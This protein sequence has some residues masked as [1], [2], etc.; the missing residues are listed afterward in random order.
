[1][2]IFLFAAM[3]LLLSA[4][5]TQPATSPASTRQPLPDFPPLSLFYKHPSED[6]NSECEKFRAQS[7]LHHCNDNQFDL[8]SLQKALSESAKFQQVALASDDSEYQ[9]LVSIAVLDQESG[10]ELGNAALSGATLMMLPMVMEKTI[11]AEVVITWHEVAI[12]KYDYS[13]PFRFSSSLFTLNNDYDTS[14]TA[15]VAEQLLADLEQENVFSG[16]FLMSA[17]EA[18]DYENDLTVPEAVAD[19]LLD[20]RYI[21]NNP[22]HGAALTFQ[23]REF[24]FDRAEVFVYP[25]RNTDWQ[26]RAA[27]SASEAQNLRNELDLMQRQG[28]IKKLNLGAVVPLHWTVGGDS[29]NGVFYDGLLTDLENKQ[30]HTATYIFTKG[31]KFVRVRAVFPMEEGSAAVKNPDDFV[32]AL[33]GDLQPPQESLFMA[34][35]RQRRRQADMP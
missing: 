12:K 15:L 3:A 35:L 10:S 16:A 18:S 5:A 27:I 1:M 33:L 2:R 6:L 17:L 24:A 28:Q 14:L 20:D 11:R 7:V 21:F 22:F 4:C 30:G 26:D 34:K 8:R 25:I 19:Y 9:A 13:I 23:H 32:K 31:D 29:Y